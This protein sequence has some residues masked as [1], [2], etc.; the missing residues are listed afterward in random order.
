[1]LLNAGSNTSPVMALMPLP[2]DVD[3]VIAS[4]L[5]EAA[6]A[7]QRGLVTPERTVLVT[8]THRV[9]AMD[10]KTALGDGRA[11]SA[12]LLASASAAARRLIAFD[13]AR[14]AEEE[15]SAISAVLLGALAASEA[16]PFGR[17][18]YMETIRRSGIGGAS[19]L[20][21]F[22]TGYNQGLHPPLSA[23][24]SPPKHPP[25]PADRSPPKHP[26][27]PAPSKGPAW[28][29]ATPEAIPLAAHPE[30]QALLER[31]AREHHEAATRRV[32]VQG[33]RRL[34]DYQDPAWASEYLDRL[35]ELRA[36]VALA[37]AA[38]QPSVGELLMAEAARHLALWMSW[39]DTIRVAEL[40]TRESRFR[41]VRL[42]ARAGPEELLSI[43][44]YLHPRLQ[45]VAD[46]LP[47][48]LG[49]HLL[50]RGWLGRMIERIAARGRIV[51]TT[52]LGG[53]MQLWAVARLKRW[54]RGS[55][56]FVVEQ[57]RINAWL[58]DV[59]AAAARL[60]LPLALEI[61]RCQQLVK[62]YGDTHARGWR[63]FETLQTVWRRAGPRQHERVA[64][65][66]AA[67]LADEEG[68]ALAKALNAPE[69][70]SLGGG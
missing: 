43:Q 61:V 24:P 44:E 50:T 14:M 10:E 40:K 7:V 17:D 2:G 36:W 38:E 8:S 5:M 3:V 1:M 23:I 63:N 33:L 67:A 69:P 57:A 55:L 56:R 62:G 66:R 12:A 54:R 45:E 48:A 64:A 39:E 58:G 68:L 26:P 60:D 52:S 20:R 42:E 27:L 34:I 37:S 19:S 21:A 22:S 28:P 30:V 47:A 15:G 11:Q 49:R 41:R 65:L 51:E 16:L 53:F 4:E 9:Y 32:V 46:T 35:A 13:M 6:R 70:Q 29:S 25:L 59:H 31:A 18:E